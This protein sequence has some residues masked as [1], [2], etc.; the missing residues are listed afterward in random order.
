MFVEV[1]WQTQRLWQRATGIE[2]P[3][4]TE[5]YRPRRPS[6]AVDPMRATRRWERAAVAAAALT[7]ATV[8][9]AMAPRA[10]LSRSTPVDAASARAP[11][12]ALLMLVLGGGIVALAML[13]VVTWAS[14]RRNDEDGP[15]RLPEPLPVLRIWNLLAI[16]LRVALGAA[17]VAAAVMG[18]QP[19]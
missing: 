17:L 1:R 8:V 5:P 11:V 12:T 16:L 13:A 19:L 14:R 2:M 15:E 7:V 3:T 6:V 10:P 4:A 18:A 9:V